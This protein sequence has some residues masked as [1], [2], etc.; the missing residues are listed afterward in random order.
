[1][2]FD[3]QVASPAGC[4]AYGGGSVCGASGPAVAAQNVKC[5]GT[6]LSLGECELE[7]ADEQ[8]N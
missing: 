3:F 1:M 4:A 6:E 2:G 5:S 8:W 7:P